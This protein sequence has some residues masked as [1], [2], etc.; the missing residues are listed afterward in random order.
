MNSC[1]FA[2]RILPNKLYNNKHSFTVLAL[3]AYPI[4]YE[5]NKKLFNSLKYK[6]ISERDEN[7][8]KS[9]KYYME[10]STIDNKRK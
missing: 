6:T 2:K 8:R 3:A 7:T 10:N 4:S 5:I 1:I 9:I